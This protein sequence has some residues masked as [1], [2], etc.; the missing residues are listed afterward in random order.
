M[1]RIKL[2]HVIRIHLDGP[3]LRVKELRM[4]A[5]LQFSPLNLDCVS[6][7]CMEQQRARLCALCVNTYSIFLKWGKLYL[8]LLTK[9]PS[10]VIY[11]QHI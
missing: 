4:A 2:K 1:G 10:T 11:K 7:R 6:L 9:T 3:K 5:V 8:N